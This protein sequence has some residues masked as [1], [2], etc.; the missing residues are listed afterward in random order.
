MRGARERLGRLANRPEVS[1]RR[2]REPSLLAGPHPPAAVACYV[3]PVICGCLLPPPS[4]VNVSQIPSYMQ[5][6]TT[7]STAYST[8]CFFHRCAQL[9]IMLLALFSWLPPLHEFNLC[10]AISQLYH[11]YIKHTHGVAATVANPW[12]TWTLSNTLMPLCT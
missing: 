12:R 10:D 9:H 7:S 6:H 4:P 11:L 5:K 1:S 2:R 8:I 3:S